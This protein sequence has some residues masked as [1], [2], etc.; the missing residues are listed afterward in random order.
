MNVCV[1]TDIVN[2]LV[3]SAGGTFVYLHK[4]RVFTFADIT[5]VP[6]SCD[7]SLCMCW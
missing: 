1:L 7:M 5:F 4:Q 2:N 3:T 6:A